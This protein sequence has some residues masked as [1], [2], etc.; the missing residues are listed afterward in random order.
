[1]NII[2]WYIY[3]LLSM[4]FLLIGLIVGVVVANRRGVARPL[5]VATGGLGAVAGE[6]L[7]VAAFRGLAGSMWPPAFIG[8]LLGSGALSALAAWLARRRV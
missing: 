3:A 4:P 8:A 6:W 1:V 2:P 5:I 7:A